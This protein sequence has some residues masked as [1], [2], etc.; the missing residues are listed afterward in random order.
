MMFKARGKRKDGKGWVVGWYYEYVST[1]TGKLGSW[2]FCT[3]DWLD[4]EV[5]DPAYST[6]QTD[7]HGDEI[8]G[9]MK[10]RDT[11]TDDLW[12][13]VWD[14]RVA[15]FRAKELAERTD[16]R[17]TYRLLSNTQHLEIIEE[18]Q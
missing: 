2:I 3:D 9:G 4:Y 1:K 5:T 18:P 11:R 16:G 7:K 8:F 15:G 6:G 13:I 17:V 14:E 12:L 10:C